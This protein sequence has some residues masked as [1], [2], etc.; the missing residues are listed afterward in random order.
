[1]RD[2]YGQVYLNEAEAMKVIYANPKIDLTTITVDNTN[3]FN[4][5]VNF[6]ASEVPNA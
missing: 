1:M 5:A 4:K 2:Q 3:K 6:W